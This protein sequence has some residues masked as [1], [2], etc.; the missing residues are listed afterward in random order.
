MMY[1]KGNV[2]KNLLKSPP[3]RKLRNKPD[4]GDERFIC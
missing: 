1:Q 4:Q 2:K 3:K